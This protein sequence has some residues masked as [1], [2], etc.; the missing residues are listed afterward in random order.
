[1]STCDLTTSVA[2]IAESVGE[3]VKA[4]LAHPG[5]LRGQQ[6][7]GGGPVAEFETL[8]AE[9]TGFPHCLATSSATSALLVAAL[10][11]DLADKRVGVERG[12]WEGSLG[13]LEAAGA[14]LVEVDSLMTASFEGFCAI[15]ATDT[16]GQRHDASGLRALC[17]QTGAVYIEDTGWLPGVTAP[18]TDMSLADIQ[19]MSFGPGKPLSLGEGGVL[20]CRDER[21][22]QRAVSLSQHPERCV[23]EGFARR[24]RP[25]LNARIHPLAALIGGCLLRSR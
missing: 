22:Y 1:M 14:D 4:M 19:V 8:L 13:A 2:D 20:L 16:R 6:V 18:K 10:A 11:L 9:R 7:R 23:A 24:E 12:C 15:V 17:N 21:I 3:Y 25:P 5:A